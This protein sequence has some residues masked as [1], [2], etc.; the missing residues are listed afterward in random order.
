MKTLEELYKEVMENEELK[1]EFLEASKD[2]E[3]MEAFLKKNGC[4]AGI[5][6]LQTFIKE[7]AIVE[8]NDEDLDYIAGGK[9]SAGETVIISLSLMGV[10]CIGK[11]VESE[12]N[13]K[14]HGVDPDSC[15]FG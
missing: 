10:L 8:V 15:T 13:K 7:K 11:A 12:I 2:K 1:K 4:E 3:T 14:Y 5:E 9:G 6:D